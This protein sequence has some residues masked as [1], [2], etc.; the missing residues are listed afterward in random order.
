MATEIDLAEIKKLLDKTG[1][2]PK[3]GHRLCGFHYDHRAEIFAAAVQLADQLS[4]CQDWGYVIECQDEEIKRLRAENAAAVEA[5]TG[6]CAEVL[7][8]VRDM[9]LRSIGNM[10]TSA[11]MQLVS[12]TYA[13]CIAAIRAKPEETP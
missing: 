8:A 13:E 5:E 6:R 11:T 9:A 4:E 3:D 2:F 1:C 7:E 12:A 10:L